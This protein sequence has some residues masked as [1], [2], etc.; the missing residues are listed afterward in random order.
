MTLNKLEV[1]RY[2]WIMQYL[3]WKICFLSLGWWWMVGR[4]QCAYY[5][6]LIAHWWTLTCLIVCNF[7]IYSKCWK[8]IVWMKY[9]KNWDKQKEQIGIWHHRN[10]LCPAEDAYLCIRI[11]QYHIVISA[12]ALP[13]W[14][15]LSNSLTQ[16]QSL[17]VIDRNGN[18]SSNMGFENLGLF[19]FNECCCTISIIRLCLV[20]CSYI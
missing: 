4:L 14:S 18:T 2:L 20:H 11:Y 5:I 7:M 9:E 8:G 16:F 15:T 6:P 12:I 13:I 10:L 19:L 3:L 17:T 1:W